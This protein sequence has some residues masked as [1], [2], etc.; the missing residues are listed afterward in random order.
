MH[1]E[2]LFRANLIEPWIKS[3]TDA[4]SWQALTG[5]LDNLS[6]TEGKRVRYGFQSDNSEV[7]QELYELPDLQW[8]NLSDGFGK[9]P[10]VDDDNCSIFLY[11]ASV[12]ANENRS[13]VRYVIAIDSTSYVG[14]LRE[15]TQILIVSTIFGV[16]IVAVVGFFIAKIGLKPLKNLSNQTKTLVPSL[17]GH[18]LDT[19]AL[20]HELKDLA[21]SFN[22]VLDKQEIAWRQLES[23]NADVAH[24]LRTPLTNLIGQTQ[25]SLSHKH[26]F[27]DLQDLLGSNLE[28]LERMTSIVNDMLFLSHAQAG[29]HATQTSMVSIRN[30]SLKTIEYIE[31]LLVDKHL[32]I[33]VNGDV[34]ARIDHRLYHRALA[35][36]LSNSA[37][38]A[39]DHS[40]V[41]VEIK[42][43]KMLASISVSNKG[44]PIDDKHLHQLFERFYRL[45]SSRSSSHIHHGLGLSIV[46]AVALMHQGNVFATSNNGINT[47]GLT[48][49]LDSGENSSNNTDLERP[50]HIRS[51]SFSMG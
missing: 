20:D 27:N 3:R 26:D 49:S 31:P 47:F 29:D 14:T 48:M 30:E 41:V 36:L 32:S 6:A 15:F 1:N 16:V 23:F 39:Y 11:I 13:A 9:I 28:E 44:D 21:T 33:V 19:L 17:K 50:Q 10:S 12:P 51:G 25:L 5:K 35:N 8:Q 46:R 18:R 22:D 45:D 38:Y 37:R 7:N 43:E 24:E 42:Q 40:S 34:E 4:N 2:L